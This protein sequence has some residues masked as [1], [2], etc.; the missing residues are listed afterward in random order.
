[1]GVVRERLE[2]M[3]MSQ[4]RLDCRVRRALGVAC[5]AGAGLGDGGGGGA[6]GGGADIFILNVDDRGWADWSPYN[7]EGVQADT[8]R[9]AQLAGEGLRF[10]NY[11]SVSPICSPSRAGLLTGQYP[12]RWGINSFIDNRANNLARDTQDFLSL[13]APMLPRALGQAGY[14]TAN[15]GKWHWGGGRDVGY[16]LAPVVMQY[17]F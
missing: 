1:M 16:S 6:A 13:S 4:A 14:A 9:A 10:T 3:N 17:G 7:T 2:R 15:V 12:S 5:A 8:P 11:Y